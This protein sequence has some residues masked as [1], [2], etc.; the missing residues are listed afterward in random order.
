MGDG[1]LKYFS[2]LV[3]VAVVIFGIR[4]PGWLGLSRFSAPD[5]K[6]WIETAHIGPM[7]RTPYY[8]LDVQ[9][10]EEKPITV[11]SVVMNDDPKCVNRDGSLF[12]TGTDAKLGQVLQF[13]L[14]EDWYAC[15][16][17]KV[18]ISTDRGDSIYTFD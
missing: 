5:F 14:G 3:L 6:V 8:I 11:Q 13:P 15:K 1:M 17:V 12:H 4:H 7:Q 16:P 9:S 10:R 18:L 2:A